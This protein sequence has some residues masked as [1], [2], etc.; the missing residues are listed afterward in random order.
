MKKV[1]EVPSVKVT[2]FSA[3]EDILSGSDVIIDIEG[4]FQN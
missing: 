1:Y 4:F 3:V 2:V